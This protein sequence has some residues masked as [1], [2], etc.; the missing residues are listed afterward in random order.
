MTRPSQTAAITKDSRA[1][2]S[3][4]TS[5]TLS[6]SPF[7]IKEAWILTWVRWFFGKLV[8]HS[9]HL[10]AFWIESLFFPPILLS[11]L[12][13]CH[14]ASSTRLDS[15]TRPHGFSVST[16][17]DPPVV[18]GHPRCI[19]RKFYWYLNSDWPSSATVLSLGVKEKKESEVA[20]SC[21]IVCDPMDCSL[22][23][24]SVHEILQARLLEW[25]A[26]SF[27]RGSSQPRDWIQVSHIASRRF[28][29]WATREALE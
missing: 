3:V 22:P 28:N 9:L 15:I 8:W 24:S 23:G 11:N 25:V 10:L 20:Q 13:A 14:V 5:H 4:T 16:A 18:Y 2:K 26:I 1:R 29:L 19:T 21:P 6:S 27:S 12:S 7:S 17:H